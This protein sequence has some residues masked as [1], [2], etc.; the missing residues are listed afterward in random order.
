MPCAISSSKPSS[1]GSMISTPGAASVT[2]LASIDEMIA[3]RRPST[4]K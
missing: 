1:Y 4:S 2:R 3:T